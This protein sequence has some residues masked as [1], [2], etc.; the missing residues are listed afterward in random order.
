MRRRGY[1]EEK[2]VL[3]CDAAKLPRSELEKLAREIARDS[4][5]VDG[6]G[7]ARNDDEAEI[8]RV[9]E[10][11]QALERDGMW[12]AAMSWVETRLTKL[13]ALFPN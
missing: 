3:N 5:G 2:S 11:L 12:V 7:A 8:L 10:A 6:K 1:S 13:V 4:P 9:W